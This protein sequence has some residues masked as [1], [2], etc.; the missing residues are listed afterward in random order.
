MMWNLGSLVLFVLIVDYAIEGAGMSKDAGAGLLS[1]SAQFNAVGRLGAAIL[2]SL[3]W[4]N[5]FYLFFVSNILAGISLLL[6]PTWETQLNFM[7]FCGCFGLF[8]G[9]QIG[10]LAVL[11]ADLFGV[12]R[13]TSAYGLQNI[14]D[15]AGAMIGPPIGGTWGLM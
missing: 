6:I 8:L 4:C 13:L 7:I 15:G 9:M 11:T 14:G 10:V 12:H 5:K 2:G 3:P 1:I